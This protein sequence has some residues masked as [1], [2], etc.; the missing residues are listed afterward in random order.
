MLAWSASRAATGFALL[1]GSVNRPSPDLYL[2]NSES[3]NTQKGFLGKCFIVD[4]SL[5]AMLAQ[6]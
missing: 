3:Q 2:I 1:Q 6:A 4:V 5:K